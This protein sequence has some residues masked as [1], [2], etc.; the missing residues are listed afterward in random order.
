MAKR[1]ARIDLLAGLDLFH[2]LSRRE[3][4]RIASWSTQLDLSEGRVVCREGDAGREAFV[5]V[6]GTATVSAGG[7]PIAV[8]RPGS[9]FGEMAVLAGTP[10]TATVVA[11]SAIS[12]LVL[13][14]Q[15]LTAVLEGLP[16]IGA[17]VRRTMVTRQRELDRDPV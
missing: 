8:L 1:D 7:E 2:G 9:M 3:L 17:Q 16:V 5:L 13:T 11:T 10:R 4:L 12:V 14:R 15:E 6:E